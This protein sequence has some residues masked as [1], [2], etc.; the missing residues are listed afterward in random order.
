VAIKIGAS[1]AAVV[2]DDESIRAMVGLVLAQDG[3]QV[4]EAV[5][6]E[7]GLRMILDDL[8]QVVVVDMQMPRLNGLQLTRRV[9][10]EGLFGD[11]VRIIIYTAGATTE[12]EALKAGADA[13]VIKAGPVR[14]LRDAI[15]G[16]APAEEP[17]APN[18]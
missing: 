13:L 12:Q 4:L 18:L 3:W 8:P 16:I 15:R 6:G 9:R 11:Q 2:D 1:T 7:S 5:D 17:L 14:R 10:D